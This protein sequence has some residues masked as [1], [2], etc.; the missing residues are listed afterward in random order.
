MPPPFSSPSSF[1]KKIQERR[2]EEMELVHH[3][4]LHQVALMFF[5]VDKFYRHKTNENTIIFPQSEI[6]FP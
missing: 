1:E 4:I 5:D 3:H 2:A 6:R